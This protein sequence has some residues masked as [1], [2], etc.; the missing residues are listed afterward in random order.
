M[1]QIALITGVSG[2]IGSATS[3]LFFENGWHV[4]GVDLQNPDTFDYINHFFKADLSNSDDLNRVFKEIK[5]NEFNLNALVNNAAVQICKPLINTLPEEWEKIIRTN[6]TSVYLIVRNVHP[7]MINRGGAIVNISSVHAIATSKNISAYAASKGAL[8]S[9]TRAMAIEFAQDNIRVN[10]V[11]PGAVDTPMLHA[12]LI[13]GEPDKCNDRDRLRE[14][15]NRTVLGRIGRPEE[16]AQAIL[17]LSDELRSSFIT[18]QMLVVDGG[19][20]ARLSTE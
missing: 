7:L 9:L 3:K 6:V 15:A 4:I 19:A 12:G 13:R 14:L 20:T 18:G 17:F 5:E 10:C 16:I 11:L 2:G 1:E 8:L